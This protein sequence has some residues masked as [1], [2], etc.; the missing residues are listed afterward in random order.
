MQCDDICVELA[1]MVGWK[2]DLVH[3][4]IPQDLEMRIAGIEGRT[5]QFLMN[6]V[7]PPPPSAAS[8]VMQ[9]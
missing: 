1:R 5:S 8:T 7:M 4:M 9:Q 3:Q 2:D 6:R